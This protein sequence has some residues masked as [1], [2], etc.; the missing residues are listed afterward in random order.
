VLRCK[1]YI[2]QVGRPFRPRSRPRNRLSRVLYLA[3]GKDEV[4]APLT[5]LETKSS[6]AIDRNHGLFIYVYPS[7][8]LLVRRAWCPGAI[9][10]RQFWKPLLPWTVCD[11]GTIRPVIEAAQEMMVISRIN[12]RT[13]D[14]REAERSSERQSMDPSKLSFHRPPGLWSEN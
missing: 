14:G 5:G 6:E 7:E 2:G 9:Q 12:R 11:Q 13:Y 1:G 4:T 8:T 10:T 3:R